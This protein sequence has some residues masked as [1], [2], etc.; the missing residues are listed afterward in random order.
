MADIVAVDSMTA[1]QEVWKRVELDHAV[2]LLIDAR[3][4]AEFARVY[5]VHLTNSGACDELRAQPHLI[6]YAELR[7]SHMA[8]R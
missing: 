5:A 6:D 1:R 7:K 8:S 2:P 4:G 3:M